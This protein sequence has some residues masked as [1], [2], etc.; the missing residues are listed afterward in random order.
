MRRK[1]LFEPPRREPSSHW[2]AGEACTR[3]LACHVHCPEFNPQEHPKENKVLSAIKGWE[4]HTFF[5]PV[6]TPFLFFLFLQG[7]RLGEETG[8]L[9]ALSGLELGEG[10]VFRDRVSQCSSGCPETHSVN[11]AGLN[12]PLCPVS[13]VKERVS[14][15]SD[16]PWTCYK[17]ALNSC[18]CLLSD[19]V[20]WKQGEP[21]LC[22]SEAST[23]P[24]DLHHY[25]PFSFFLFFFVFVFETGFLCIALAVLELT[26]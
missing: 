6:L 15:I 11:Q 19:L 1:S 9:V 5:F 12:V 18:F 24:S 25:S 22:R 4:L 13:F 14:G 16:W 21:G 26:L 17:M 3:M 7:V 8:S 10:R 23:L 20:L 2:S